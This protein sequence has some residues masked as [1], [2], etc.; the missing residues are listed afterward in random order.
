M[1]LFR[2][3]PKVEKFIESAPCP[4]R[5]DR[6][7]RGRARARGDSRAG[8][9]TGQ[10]GRPH[11]SAFS[12]RLNP[13]MAAVSRLRPANRARIACAAPEKNRKLSFSAVFLT[14]RK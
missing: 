8:G 5:P 2:K 12:A 3:P 9:R 14:A 6:P 13:Q 4:R 10:V 11:H 7:F 1:L